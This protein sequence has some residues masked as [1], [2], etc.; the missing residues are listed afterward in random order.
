MTLVARTSDANIISAVNSIDE[1]EEQCELY[2]EDNHQTQS[3]WLE[4]SATSETAKRSLIASIALT[5]LQEGRFG[6]LLGHTGAKYTLV[7][8]H[9]AS[10]EAIATVGLFDATNNFVTNDIFPAIAG[11]LPARIS[12]L[13]ISG[14]NGLSGNL[15]KIWGGIRDNVGGTSDFNPIIEMELGSLGSSDVSLASDSDNASPYGSTDNLVSFACTTSEAE[16]VA[17]SMDEATSTTDFSQFPGD[18]TVLM[19][20]RLTV[21]ESVRMRLVTGYWGNTTLKYHPYQYFSDTDYQLTE[22]GVISLPP[23]S[24]L[25]DVDSIRNYRLSLYVERVGA[26]TTIQGDCFVLI[27]YNHRFSVEDCTL[28]VT[29]TNLLRLFI[30]E[31]DSLTAYNESTDEIPNLSIQYAPS[32]F[33]HPIAGGNFVMCAQQSTL[34][35]VIDGLGY[36]LAYN[37]KFRTHGE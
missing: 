34:S 36:V 17:V 8:I 33:T 12:S 13:Y 2:W 18:Y 30:W 14:Q 37:G 22:M 29:G 6:P 21:A 15:T 27:P 26:A 7:I 24:R 25:N 16:V 35:N 32:D 9:S 20:A 28:N 1:L 5:P 4:E 23:F 3:V 10:W 19:R 31:D 11:S